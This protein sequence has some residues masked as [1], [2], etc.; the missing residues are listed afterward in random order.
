MKIHA[1]ILNKT[2]GNQIRQYIKKIICHGQMEFISWLQS[3]FNIHKSVNGIIP[4]KQN[5]GSRSYINRCRKRMIKSQHSFIIKTL[6]KVGKRSHTTNS[7]ANI[8][9]NGEQLKAFSLISGTR[10]GCLHHHF[11]LTQYWKS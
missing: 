9:L 10:K 5:E 2:V 3:L 7:T 8:I 11:Y 4:Q 6:G 1:K